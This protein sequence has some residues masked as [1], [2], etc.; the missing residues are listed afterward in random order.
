M[1]R[2]GRK[3][4]QRRRER[5]GRPKRETRL[6]SKADIQSVVKAQP[7]RSRYGDNS[8]DARA[9]NELG[10]LWL[11]NIITPEQHEAGSR[12]RQV[13]GAMQRA[14]CA[15]KPTPKSSAA[16][17]LETKGKV[18]DF[19]EIDPDGAA[20]RANRARSEYADAYR[21]LSDCGRD[22]TL[23][24]NDVV[25]FDYSIYEARAGVIDLKRGLNALVNHFGLEGRRRA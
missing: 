5:N 25:L 23:A 22:S 13:V 11:D 20:K 14:I 21:A 15:P 3:R 17:L 2:R 6:E 16:I 12:Y 7:H 18:I 1:A 4:S 10:R 9:G 8:D 24:V 19:D